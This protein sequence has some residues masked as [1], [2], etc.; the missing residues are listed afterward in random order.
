M[1]AIDETPT[2]PLDYAALS[3]AYG[4]LL[5]TLAYAVR[6]RAK[7]T[8]P[9]TS[10]ELLPLGVAT[11]TL[12]RAI[13]HEKVETWARQP[14]VEEDAAGRRRPKGR[15]LRYAVGEILTCTRCTGTWGALGLVALRVARPPAGRA[16]IS[17]LAAAGINDFLQ[18]GFTYC[19]ASA[20]SLESRAA[21]EERRAHMEPLRQA[22]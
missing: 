18:S 8:D 17:V 22:S 2:E 15:R 4:G 10:A 3:A 14:F 13:V 21:E 19:T 20:N 1:R 16:I 9:L 7:E 11:F 6:H 5:V 12:S